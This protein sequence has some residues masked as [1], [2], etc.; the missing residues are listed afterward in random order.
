V[1][2]LCG[3]GDQLSFANVAARARWRGNPS[4][5]HRHS[6][7]QPRIRRVDA[8]IRWAEREGIN[9]LIRETGR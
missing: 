5:R 2:Q 6:A 3:C 9:A 7:C 1:I 8:E 4:T